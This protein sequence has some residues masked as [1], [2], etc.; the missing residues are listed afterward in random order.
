MSCFWHIDTIPAY[1]AKDF[2]YGLEMSDL[3]KS[4]KK[5]SESQ[6]IALAQLIQAY[7]EKKYSQVIQ[8]SNII[9]KGIRNNPRM[10]EIV[11][12]SERRLKQNA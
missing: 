4:Q 9:P 1:C 10:I 3:P 2:I 5:I 8:L 12:S 7:R 11:N 6:K